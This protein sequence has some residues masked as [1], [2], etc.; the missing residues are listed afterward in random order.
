M[1]EKIHIFISI[2]AALVTLVFGISAG[3]GLSEIAPPFI[4][5][6]IIFYAAGLMVRKYLVKNVFIPEDK[7]GAKAA[8]PDISEKNPPDDI[9][10]EY[11]NDDDDFSDDDPNGL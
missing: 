5:A 11:L 9:R 8:E 3:M 6:V 2:L 7:E 1:V 10:R 4:A